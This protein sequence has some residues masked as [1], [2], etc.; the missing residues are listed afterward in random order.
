MVDNHNLRNKISLYFNYKYLLL[1]KILGLT[2]PISENTAAC[3]VIDGK[4]VAFAEE[5]RFNW[6]KH[7]PRMLP[8]KAILYCLEKASLS[9]DDIDCIAIWYD[10]FAKWWI[11]NIISNFFKEFNFKR[12]FFEWG[13]YV[14]YFFKMVRLKWF[15]QWLAIDKKKIIKKIRYYSHHLAHAASTVRVSWFDE[16]LILSFDGVGE[17][18]AWLLWYLRNN[19]IHKVK[20]IKINQ[21]LWWLYSTVTW[22]CWFK[23][24][25]HEGKLMWLAPYGKPDLSIFEWIAEITDSGYI[26]KNNWNYKLNKKYKRRSPIDEIT[27]EYKDLAA[28]VQYFLEL[29]GQNTTK[30][31]YQK[32]GIKNVCLAWWVSLNCD[33]NSKILALDC[34]E[35]IHIQPAANDAWTALW[36]ALEAYVELT[37]KKCEKQNHTYFWPNYSDEE[38][39]QLLIESKLKYRKLKSIKEVAEKIHEWKTIWLFQGRME[40]WPRALWNRSIV[41]NPSLLWI[42][43]KINVEVKHREEWRPFAPSVLEEYAA[44]YFEKYYFSPYMILTFYVKKEKIKDL[45]AV[46]HVDNTARVQAVSKDTNP[47]YYELINEFYKLSWVPVLLNTSFNDKEKPI[48]LSPRDAVQTFYTTWIDTL[49]LENFILEK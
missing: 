28:T 5:E 26:L 2:A 42:K 45:N 19:K 21:S 39:E 27:Q 34:I 29:A 43:D 3:V 47:K 40:F 44:E 18:E 16:S 38:I 37:W 20:S 14:E 11:K 41:A 25:S 4:L 7:A 1:M 23:E 17:N 6:L 15:L 10:S 33:M 9:I 12:W 31:L 36:A 48:C 30:W 32:V 22:I 13:A 49:V 8:Q 24:H 46:I 35:N